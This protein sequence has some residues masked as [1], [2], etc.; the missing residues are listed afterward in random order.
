MKHETNV[1][2][3]IKISA[4]DL[5]F[6]KALN[7]SYISNT[8][9]EQLKNS[10]MLILPY[11]NVKGYTGPVFPEG[12]MDFFRYLES[13]NNKEIN[14]DICADDDIYKELILHSDLVNIGLILVNELALPIVVNFIWYYIQNNLLNKNKE[15]KVKLEIIVEKNGES[16]K[17][18]YEGDAIVFK[19]TINEIIKASE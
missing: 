9:K 1:N 12:T 10:Q 13:I 4:T 19:E 6:E 18:S 2:K 15:Q 17:I 5:N 16:K 11:E 14:I 8:L 3:M 7:K